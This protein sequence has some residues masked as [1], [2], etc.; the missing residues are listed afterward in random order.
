LYRLPLKEATTL[1]LRLPPDLLHQ[2]NKVRLP[3]APS[4]LLLLYLSR[5]CYT[6]IGGDHSTGETAAEGEE[7]GDGGAEDEDS[8]VEMEEVSGYHF[9]DC[10][11]LFVSYI[12]VTSG[13][14]QHSN[15]PLY[16][17]LLIHLL[18]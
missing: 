16:R 3:H 15:A 7:G 5:C 6:Q 14:R 12:Y 11:P 1:G 4:I 13:A 18:H 17:Y 9:M 8:D 10:M 2:L